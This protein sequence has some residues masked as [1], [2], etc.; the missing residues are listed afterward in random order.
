[1][2]AGRGM[3]N[4]QTKGYRCL[5]YLYSV[6]ISD[7]IFLKTLNA[8]NIFVSYTLCLSLIYLLHSLNHSY[9][10]FDGV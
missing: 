5:L 4:Y 6:Y 1:M 8:K 2:V 7:I 3:K 10:D 9:Y